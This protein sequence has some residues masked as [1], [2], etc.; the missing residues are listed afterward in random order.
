MTR[1]PPF[2]SPHLEAA[3]RV[4]AD[5]E[6]GLTGTQIGRLLQEIRIAD[7]TPGMTKWKRLFNALVEVQNT[8]Q[9]GN[10]LIMLVNRAMNPV[11]FARDHQSFAWR[12]SPVDQQPQ[13]RD[14]NKPMINPTDFVRILFETFDKSAVSDFRNFLNANPLV[15]KWIIAADFCLHDKDRPNHAFAF[16]IIPYDAYPDILKA[17]IRGALPKDLK[18]TKKV[19]D[20]AVA[21]LTHPRRFHFAFVFEKPPAV[22]YN[23]AD[24]EPL[25]VA[26]ESLDMTLEMMRKA[27]RGEESLRRIKKLKQRSLANNFNVELLADMYVLSYLLSFVT[28]LLAR[29]RATEIVGWFSDRDSMT[30]WCDGVVWVIA[31]ENVHGL[32]QYLNICMPPSSPFVAVPAPNASENVMWYDE[33]IRLPDYIAGILSAWNLA[34]NQLPGDKEKYLRLAED[35][36]ADARNMAIIKIR[37][38]DG[39]QCSRIVF[40]RPKF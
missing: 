8:H 3:C 13:A 18:K 33:F 1:I 12:P 5:T 9:V 16:T 24:T 32:A 10:Y 21:F 20:G 36:I 38:D 19:Q 37:W 2:N 31:N 27:G 39:V 4:L 23:G 40:D 22:F 6:R 30:T 11:N 14:R 34:T 26:R 35:V 17:D 15:K 29:E 7:P 28:I 25:K